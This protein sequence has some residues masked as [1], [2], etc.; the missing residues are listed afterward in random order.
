[1]YVAFKALRFLTLKTASPALASKAGLALLAAGLLAPLVLEALPEKT[2]PPLPNVIRQPLAESS[3]PWRARKHRQ[4]RRP[5]KAQQ[6]VAKEWTPPE[7]RWDLLA[8]IAGLLLAAGSFAF[9]LRS[10]L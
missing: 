5:A 1:A 6:P 8:V 9:L 7:I 4:R 10:A 3:R 2:L